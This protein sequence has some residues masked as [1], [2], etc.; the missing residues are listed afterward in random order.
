MV[1]SS[2][3][4]ATMSVDV[5]VPYARQVISKSD[6]RFIDKQIREGKKKKDGTFTGGIEGWVGIDKASEEYLSGLGGNA[7]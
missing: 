3:D 7:S 5:A 6:K 4:F 1:G 2:P